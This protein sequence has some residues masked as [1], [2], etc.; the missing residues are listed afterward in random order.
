MDEIK[1]QVADLKIVRE[2]WGWLT[3]LYGSA[4][5]RTKVVGH[6][7]GVEEG[8]TVEC[9]GA[10]TEHPKFGRQFKAIEIRA[11]APTDTSGAIAWMMSRLPQV[12]RKHATAMIE[13]WGLPG[14]WRV[15]EHSPG[16][17][18][19][20]NGITPERARR[21]HERYMAV[22]PE[23]DRIVE[24]R[25]IGL[26]DRQAAKVVSKWGTAAIDKIRAN[27]YALAEH[28]DGFGF[29]RSD[30]VARRLGLP[31]E[32]PS[33]IRAGLLHTMGEA[34]GGGH[35]AVAQPKLVKM[36]ASEKVLDVDVEVVWPVLGQLLREGGLVL[37]GVRRDVHTA[38]IA[39]SEAKVA[40]GVLRL[41][42]RRV[43]DNHG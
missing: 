40:G 8:D 22:L 42:G 21:I 32:H 11:V 14:V 25:R 31:K 9:K 19:T 37:W 35:T 24:L 1:G 6:P 28:V 12:G 29:L 10:W 3:L 34:I 17:L 15:L 4:N 30:A 36:A 2:G 20:L 7:L 13:R 39:A 27:P 38:P 18:A 33:R 43:G 41:L 5:E 16:D 23:R 26:T